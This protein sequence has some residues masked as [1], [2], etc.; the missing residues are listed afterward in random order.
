MQRDFGWTVYPEAW[1]R[2]GG[3]WGDQWYLWGVPVGIRLPL[4]RLA[5]VQL[6][7]VEK[8]AQATSPGILTVCDHAP[9]DW[10]SAHVRIPEGAGRWIDIRLSVSSDGFTKTITVANNT[11]AGAL[12]LQPWLGG[13][14]LVSAEPEGCVVN[15]PPGHVSWKFVGAAA[16][17][18]TVHIVTA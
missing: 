16:R 5:G 3:L 15:D 8:D 18:A 12:F 4:E 10:A 2:D 9:D 11:A 1:D 14:R 17:G 7:R 13:R 6:S